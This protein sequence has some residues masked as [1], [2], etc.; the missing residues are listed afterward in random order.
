MIICTVCNHKELIGALF[1]SECGAELPQMDVQ[2]T[3]ERLDV[4]EASTEIISMSTLVT[5]PK[6]TSLPN[7]RVSLSVEGTDEIIPLRE[8]TEFTLGRMSEHQPLMPD[9]DLTPFQAFERG[10]SRLHATI[11]ID[12]A[13][14]F[15]IDLGSANGTLLNGRKLPPQQPQPLADGDKISLGKFKLRIIIN[16]S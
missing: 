12:Q 2:P 7:T 4:G 1:C 5:T 15:L 6:I 14:I 10:V 16:Y 3:P 11:K 9:I 8:G 13:E